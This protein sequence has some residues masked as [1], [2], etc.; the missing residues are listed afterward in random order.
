MNAKLGAAVLA[1]CALAGCSVIFDMG[2]YDGRAESSGGPSSS[3]GSSGG[4]ADGAVDVDGDQAGIGDGGTTSRMDAGDDRAP[5]VTCA[6]E[7]EPNDDIPDADPFEP[8]DTCGL[9]SGITD[10]DFFRF[11]TTTSVTMTFQLASSVQL[12]IFRNGSTTPDQTYGGSGGSV[13]SGPGN[14]VVVV[15]HLGTQ[16]PPPAYRLTR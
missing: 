7:S 16:G 14:Y 11:T 3:S 6:N 15:S 5:P 1:G 12:E 8:G 13:T 2:D 10:E 9:L 4:R